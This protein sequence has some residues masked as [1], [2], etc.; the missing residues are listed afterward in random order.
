MP[1]LLSTHAPSIPLILD[2]GVLTHTRPAT[3]ADYARVQDFHARCSTTSRANRYGAGRSGL[4]EDEW[5][6]LLAGPRNRVLVTTPAKD[7]E[8]VV[9]MT[10]LAE[11]LRNPGTCDLAVLIAD[12]SPDA[13]QSRGL[14]TQLAKHAVDLASNLGFTTLSATVAATN[15]R[16]LLI[17]EHLGSPAL[18]QTAHLLN[19]S[20]L[21][22]LPVPDPTPSDEVELRVTLGGAR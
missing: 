9:A 4:T 12:L 15:W 21:G 22:A 20:L 10:T 17:M 16:A 1:S 18:P 6:R 3:V 14:G 8:R 5:Q 11:F 13:F 7:L 2:D 19:M